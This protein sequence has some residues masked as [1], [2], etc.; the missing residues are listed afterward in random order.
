[1][2]INGDFDSSILIRTIKIDNNGLFEICS[3]ASVVSQSD[4]KNE[5]E[6]VKAKLSAMVLNLNARN[7]I[8]KDDNQKLL[9]LLQFDHDVV[10]TLYKRNQNLSGFWFFDKANF[11]KPVKNTFVNLNAVIINNED[12]FVNMLGHIFDKIG[13]KS[14]IV[15]YNSFNINDYNIENTFFVIGPGPGDPNNTKDLKITR[16]DTIVKDI[17]ESGAR[18]CGICLGHQIISKHL[19]FSLRLGKNCTQ[20]EQ[21]EIDFF[22]EKQL[23]GFYNTFYAENSGDVANKNSLET[24]FDKNT[25]DI[26]AIRGERFFSMQ[27]HPESLLTQNGYQIILNELER[28]YLFC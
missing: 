1:M 22:N 7:N 23:V 9:S 19:G 14:S 25:N 21:K 18:F 17:F 26:Y 15:S 27:F 13:I 6:E 3:G 10:E 8:T 5:L 11:F 4:P 2:D 24:C 20:G 16:L 12:D 28:L